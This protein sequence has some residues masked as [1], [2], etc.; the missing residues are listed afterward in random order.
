MLNRYKLE[1][2]TKKKLVNEYIH[3]KQWHEKNSIP[4]SEIKELMQKGSYYP[5]N[6]AYLID[7]EHFDQLIKEAKQ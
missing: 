4:I 1:K 5:D 6:D 2:L 7:A 3:L